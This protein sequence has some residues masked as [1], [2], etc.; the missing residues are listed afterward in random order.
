[1]AARIV[2][3]EMLVIGISLAAGGVVEGAETLT[4]NATGGPADSSTR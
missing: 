3:G 4:F 2:C 1:L